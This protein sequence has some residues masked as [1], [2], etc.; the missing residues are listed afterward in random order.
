MNEIQINPE[1]RD[2]IPPLQLEEKESLEKS[3]LEEGCRDKL[4]TWDKT[5]IDGHN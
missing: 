3:I 5:I 1:L 2:L 4:I